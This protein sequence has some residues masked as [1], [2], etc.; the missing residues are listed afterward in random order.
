[1]RFQAQ[2]LDDPSFNPFDAFGVSTVPFDQR[3]LEEFTYLL[4]QHSYENFIRM[5]QQK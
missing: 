4:K 2:Q 3:A 5:T 1:M